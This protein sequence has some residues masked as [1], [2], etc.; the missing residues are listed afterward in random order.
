LGAGTNLTFPLL[1]FNLGLEV[2]QIVIVAL[3]FV[4]GTILTTVFHFPEILRARVLSGMALL[5]S[6]LLLID[7]FPNMIKS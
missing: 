6:L 2:G 7:R 4:M 1:S 3:I 5:L